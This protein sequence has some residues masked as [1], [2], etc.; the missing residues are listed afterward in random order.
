MGD[1]KRRVDLNDF[2]SHSIFQM[3]FSFYLRVVEFHKLETV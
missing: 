1:K 3:T 2:L